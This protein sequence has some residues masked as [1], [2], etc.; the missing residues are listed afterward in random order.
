MGI[1]IHSFEI[2]CGSSQ[3]QSSGFRPLEFWY[4]SR[5]QTCQDLLGENLHFSKKYFLVLTASKAGSQTPGTSNAITPSQ[6][7]CQSEMLS[8]NC[9]LK[10]MYIRGFSHLALLMQKESSITSISRMA[11]SKLFS[12]WINLGR[13]LQGWAPGNTLRS[14]SRSCCKANSVKHHVQK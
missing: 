2:S 1:V 3:D 12:H 5:P 8:W 13:C 10:F 14:F 7:C 6:P 4:L 11:I 9:D